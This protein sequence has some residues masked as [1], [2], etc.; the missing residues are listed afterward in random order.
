MLAV[1]ELQEIVEVALFSGR[2]AGERPLSLL[3]IA[4]VGSGKSELLAHYPEHLNATVLYVNDIT[5]FALHKHHG[6]ELREGKIRHIIL[7][8]LLTPLNKQKEQADAFITFM[9]GVIEEGLARVESRD[10]CFI[11]DVPVRCGLVTSIARQDFETRHTR[12]ATV[13]F[14]SRL[15]P[16]SYSY[17]QDTILQ[18]FD[19]IIHG[20]YATDKPIA[21]WLPGSDVSVDLPIDIAREL[22][23]LTQR[24]K[25][26]EDT[27]GF[28]RLKQLQVWVKA[29][30]LYRGRHVVTRD[31][32]ARLFELS[33]YMNRRCEKQL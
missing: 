12:W 23:P 1:E 25:D 7:G 3:V 9:N 27:Y 20:R 28:R 30:A 33:V 29:H 26:S 4:D 6:K 5:A 15:L 8:D 32:L 21:L 22:I 13:G 31:D 24:L 11:A 14:L 2:L 10:S 17:S 18:V 16:I 19:Y